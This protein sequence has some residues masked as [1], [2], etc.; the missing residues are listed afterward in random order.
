MDL[1]AQVQEL[2]DNAPQ[3]GTTPML[4]GA[5]APVLK[6]IAMQLR[7]LQYY[8]VQTLDKGWAVTLLSH[9]TQPNSQKQVIYAFPTLKDASNGP[10]S[11]KDPEMLVLPVPVTHILFQ[12]AAMDTVDSLIF[13]EVPGNVLTGTE[14]RRSD[15]QSLIQAQLRQTNA[16]P[17]PNIP[18]NLA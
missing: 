11:I 10:Y 15:L 3:D 2:I 7:H 17:A 4:V 13:F 1:D 16:P 18:S 8:V 6:Q 14:I 5:I 9:E 12:M